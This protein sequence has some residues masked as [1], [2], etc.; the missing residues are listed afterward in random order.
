MAK[1]DKDI[2]IS[3][4]VGQFFG[5]LWGATTKPAPPDQPRAHEVGRETSERE[6]EIDGKKIV[7]RRTT[8]DEIEIRE[9][10]EGR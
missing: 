9:D 7:L 5:H 8:I 2:S 4:A 6:G 10:E 3:R 1:D